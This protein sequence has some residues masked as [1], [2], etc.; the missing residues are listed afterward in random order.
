M[1]APTLDKDED[2]AKM[3]EALAVDPDAGGT[4]AQAAE[5]ELT[6]Q[7]HETLMQC[8]RDEAELQADER[9]QMAI[10]WDY[11][12]HLHWRPEDAAILMSRGQAP[13]VFNEGRMTIEW[14]CGIHKRQRTDYK[15]LPRQKDDEASAEAKTKVFKYVSDANLAAWHESYA[16]RQAA[17]SGLG[18]LE[19]GINT[20]PGEE[21]IF[22]GSE[23][24]RNVFRDSRSRHFDLNVDSRYLFRKKRM[25]LDY[26]IALLPHARQHLIQH[27]DKIG[28]ERDS[29]IWYLGERLT[30]S[31]DLAIAGDPNLPSRYRDR[32]AYIG[33]SNHADTGR[34]RSLDL[35][36]AW[37]T[38]PQAVKVF[39]NGPQMGKVF[40]PKLEGHQ[41]L[42][43][44]AW[45]M[46]TAVQRAMRVMVCT[47]DA[48]VWDGRSPFKHGKFL[49]VPVWG[50]RRGRDG[51]CYGL[52]RGMRDLN[53]DL[54][55]RASK[56]LHAASSNRMTFR[57]G[58]FA[59]VELARA[60]A[61]RPDMALEVDTDLNDV[62]FEKPMQDM[63]ANMELLA[64][65]REMIRNTGGVTDANLGRDSRAESGKAIGLIQ[66]QGSLVTSE[67]PDSLRLAKQQ[68][69]RL[70]LAHI[71]QF[72]PEERAIRIVGDG[73]PIEWLT[74]NKPLPDGTVLNDIT[75]NEADY[76][77]AERDYRESYAAAAMEQ[78][79]ELLGQIAKFA[80]QAVLNLLDLVVENAEIRGKE[81]WVTRIRAINGQRDPSKPLTPDEEAARLKAKQDDD[82]AKAIQLETLQAGL[83]KLRKEIEK[84]DTGAMLQRVESMFSAL[85][86]AQIVAMTPGVAPVADVIA[87][88]AGFK[89]QGGEDPN[90]PAAPVAAVPPLPGAPA[91]PMTRGE[92]PGPADAQP[93]GLEG[94]QGGIETPTPADNGPAM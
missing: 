41:Q 23:D 19:E 60:E 54:N 9:V 30:G 8:L 21:R 65:D 49:L 20:T 2:P 94:V 66:D 42:Q 25:D 74:I 64:F 73:T 51:A 53:D 86:A 84:L 29:D 39:A 5:R 28:E 35:I 92:L 48:A 13:L 31:T 71:E 83:D 80:P 57:K 89:D 69:G 22:S 34:R 11:Q 52:W 10:D 77:I 55:K 93:Q 33:A 58:A 76:I 6:Q 46:Y 68:A 3:P 7:R 36:E 88:G 75:S 47:E 82:R 37:Y 44:D 62:R 17:V 87:Q 90:L 27:A 40:D 24:W 14:V 67:L 43:R 26:S 61:A 15:I 91:D 85:Q 63:Q 78:M 18:W 81:E 79:F 72:M 56:A 1:F 50:Y 4:G 38:V 59:D 32:A 45:K 70:R 16:Y 12:D